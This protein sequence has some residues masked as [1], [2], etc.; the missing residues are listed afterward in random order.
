MYYDGTTSNDV[1]ISILSDLGPASTV[2][3]T[4]TPKPTLTDYTETP[5][6]ALSNDIFARF[7]SYYK[8]YNVSRPSAGGWYRVFTSKSSGIFGKTLTFAITTGYY[9]SSGS[10]V[11]A[12]IAFGM[13][14]EPTIFAISSNG[15][16]VDKVR[17]QQKIRDPITDGYDAYVDIHLTTAQP[18][19]I[20]GIE[21][22]YFNIVTPPTVSEV[23]TGFTVT[24][25]DCKSGIS[26]NKDINTP[27]GGK[28][29][30]PKLQ[31]SGKKIQMVDQTGAI[32]SEVD[33]SSLIP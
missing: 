25:I 20:R 6:S 29:F 27:D 30:E 8:T 32:K 23:E 11:L 26:C 19:N 16:V 2:V 33:L 22:N 1:C 12:H 3:D 14:H 28:A 4:V 21:A 7:E 10:S 13:D 5:L 9:T 17:V 18:Y 24:S 31:L 15:V